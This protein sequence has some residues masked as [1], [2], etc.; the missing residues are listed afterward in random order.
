MPHVDDFAPEGTR[1]L[2]AAD[3]CAGGD[4]R[5]LCELAAAKAGVDIDSTFVLQAHVAEHAVWV[6]V[7]LP[8]Q[9]RDPKA[10]LLHGPGEHDT[11]VLYRRFR[12]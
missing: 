9:R 5:R 7:L 3:F 2:G 8:S 1:T 4:S 11:T 10:V 6:D 12:G